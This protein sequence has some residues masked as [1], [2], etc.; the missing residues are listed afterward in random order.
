MGALLAL[1]PNVDINA[2]GL[3]TKPAKSIAWTFQNYGGYLVDNT[4]RSVYAL[5]TERGPSGAVVD[6]F[7]SKWG[8][9]FDIK[10]LDTAWARDMRSIFSALNV[11]DNNSAT[12]VGGGGTPRQ[13]LAPPFSN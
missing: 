2:M 8:L 6:E 7:R 13:P 1:P 3:E 5:E 9:D 12:S 10:E 11:V 4:G